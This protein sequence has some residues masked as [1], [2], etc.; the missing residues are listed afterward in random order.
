MVVVVVVLLVGVGGGG[1][2]G[3]GRLT[4]AFSLLAPRTLSGNNS[5]EDTD[6]LRRGEY[7]GGPD[8]CA[9]DF[10]TGLMGFTVKGCTL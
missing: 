6:F 1:C 10:E 7:M 3:N 5:I 4:C 9:V 8:G 2:R